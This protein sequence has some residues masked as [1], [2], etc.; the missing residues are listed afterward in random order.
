[1]GHNLKITFREVTY[2]RRERLLFFVTVTLAQ[3]SLLGITLN[4]IWGNME[5]V[6]MPGDELEEGELEN[7]MKKEREVMGFR[8]MNSFQSKSKFLL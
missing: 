2:K 7:G 1:M 4:E 6:Q 8:E 3:L 5:R